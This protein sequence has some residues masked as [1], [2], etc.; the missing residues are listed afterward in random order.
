[1]PQ[2]KFPKVLHQWYLYDH[3]N[4]L[5]DKFYREKDFQPDEHF[6]DIQSLL[7]QV[8]CL[9]QHQKF[10]TATKIFFDFVF[11]SGN[12][13]SYADKILKIA[14]LILKCYTIDAEIL[15]FIVQKN[16]GKYFQFQ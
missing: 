7:D 9:V 2:N 10:N 15:F 11:Y 13:N 6:T 14:Q 5:V 12:I 3:L 16:F 4:P 8:S 1:L